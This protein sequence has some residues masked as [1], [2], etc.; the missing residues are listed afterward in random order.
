MPPSEYVLGERVEV[1]DGN[2]GVWSYWRQGTVT[3]VAPVILVQCDGYSPSQFKFVRKMAS[4][5]PTYV[6]PKESPRIPV[7]VKNPPEAKNFC[8]H[9]FVYDNNGSLVA[10]FNFVQ[11][12]FYPYIIPYNFQPFQSFHTVMPTPQYQEEVIQP[13]EVSSPVLPKAKEAEIEAG[14]IPTILGETHFELPRH[15]KCIFNGA[16]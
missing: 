12:V 8:N 7:L 11:P 1:R 5:P 13:P 10:P 15:V 2:D 6:A 14:K 4:F 9:G 16:A 3:Q